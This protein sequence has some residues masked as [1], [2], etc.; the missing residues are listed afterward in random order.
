ML[1]NAD[2]QPKPTRKQVLFRLVGEVC[3]WLTIAL[4]LYTIFTMR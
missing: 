4:S 3:F 1:L 2:R